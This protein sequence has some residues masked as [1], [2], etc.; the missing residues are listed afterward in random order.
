MGIWIRSQDKETLREVSNVYIE[1]LY[2]HKETKE[3]YGSVLGGKEN[4][5]TVYKVCGMGIYSS[6]EKAIKVL[7]M[8]QNQIAKAVEAKTKYLP[9]SKD[10]EW[11]SCEH[12]SII[13]F[14]M[15]L[16]EEV[17]V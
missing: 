3:Y 1:M 9:Y 8:I 16:D 17:E 4:F 2:Q 5:I 7:D 6:K 12:V 14:N 10:S 11:S 15:P 13:V